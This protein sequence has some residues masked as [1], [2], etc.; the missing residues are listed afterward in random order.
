MKV[1]LIG[2]ENQGEGMSR[3]MVQAGIE[4]WGYREDYKKAEESF[5]N[6]YVSGVT[7][8]I[9]NLVKVVHH[10]DNQVG[11]SPGI[12]QL[13][14]PDELVEDTLDQLLPLLG[15]GDIIIDYSNRDVKK[16]QEI[17]RYCS[18]LGISYILSGIYG[19]SYA[20]DTCSK[21]FECLSPGNVKC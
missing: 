16:G 19:A 11:E 18:K 2:L 5:E 21:I 1:G 17:E 7:T 12:F 15:D 14:V 4:V 3:R 10:Q 13:V 6:G 8:T 20:I 9:E